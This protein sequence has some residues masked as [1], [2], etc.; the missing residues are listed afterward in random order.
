MRESR[1]S[2]FQVSG[3]LRNAYQMIPATTCG[4]MEILMVID[5]FLLKRELHRNRMSMRM[6]L[7]RA[8]LSRT[9]RECMMHGVPVSSYTLAR[10][11]Y[12]LDCRQD[13]LCAS[14]FRGEREAVT[15]AL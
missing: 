14:A 11:C 6:L 8:K 7:R 3:L 5:L 10:I 13:V 12:V 2:L 4:R 9:E 1:V 15:V